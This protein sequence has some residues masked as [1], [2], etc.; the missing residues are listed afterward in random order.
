MFL[1]AVVYS[2]INQVK[3]LVK[4]CYHLRIQVDMMVL[5]LRKSN[6]TIC[7]QSFIVYLIQGNIIELLSPIILPVN[8][9]HGRSVQD[10][11]MQL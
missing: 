5:V 4:N 6:P 3:I 9:F 11:V 7:H 1:F 10:H 2:L 8:C